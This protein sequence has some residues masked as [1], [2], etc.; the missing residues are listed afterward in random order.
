MDDQESFAASGMAQADE[1]YLLDGDV[2]A[3]RH[4]SMRNDAAY[5]PNEEAK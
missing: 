3:V 2:S 1:S 4:R 5:D